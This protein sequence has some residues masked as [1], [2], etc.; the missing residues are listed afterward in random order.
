MRVLLFSL[1]IIIVVLP[2]LA[3]A[4]SNGGVIISP[5][6]PTVFVSPMF[7]GSINVFRPG[8]SSYL[9]TPPVSGSTI[10]RGGESAYY[11]PFSP[12]PISS[13]GRTPYGIV[14]PGYPSILDRPL[15]PYGI[16]LPLPDWPSFP[17][18]R[19]E[20]DTSIA[21]LTVVIILTLCSPLLSP[22]AS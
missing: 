10:T 16:T 5:G 3:E 4:Q 20:H 2:S 11:I 22:L 19:N 12:P 21:C 15:A 14:M 8:Q 9:F 6:Q 13:L 18:D 7:D 17:E 1:L